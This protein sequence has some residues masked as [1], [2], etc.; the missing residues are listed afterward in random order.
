MHRN[1]FPIYIFLLFSFSSCCPLISS[2][3]LSDPGDAQYDKRIEGAWK[4]GDDMA[5]FLHFGKGPANK[6]KAIFVEHKNNGKVDYGT[7]TVFPTSINGESYLNLNAREWY[8]KYTG[9]IFLRYELSDH[10][11]L[12]LSLIDREPVINAIK[13]K[14]LEGEI[15]YTKKPAIKEENKTESLQKNEK[16][17]VACVKITDNSKNI[18]KFFQ[19]MDSKKLFSRHLKFIK[20]K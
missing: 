14:K 11:T 16:T 18:I 12:I 10:D 5:V 8:D 7:F 20:I 3:P 2:H 6:T 13:S 15:T 19:S 17:S 1:F 4:K 9:Y